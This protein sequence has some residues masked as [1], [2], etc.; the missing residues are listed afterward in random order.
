MRP[1]E[2]FQ[3]RAMHVVRLFFEEAFHRCLL[4]ADGD[5]MRQQMRIK[6][7]CAMMVT[8]KQ[9]EEAT[10]GDIVGDFALF[11]TMTK[12]NVMRI[13]TKVIEG[14]ASL[15]DMPSFPEVIQ[16]E[17]MKVEVL[18]LVG[19][20]VPENSIA[21]TTH[22]VKHIL[23]DAEVRPLRANEKVPGVAGDQVLVGMFE[24]LFSEHGSNP[25]VRRW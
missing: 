15:R 9:I 14:T 1:Y 11:S 18:S 25:E 17:D 22:E 7:T 13:A 6:A 16:M 4:D 19:V 10:M 23:E 8:F 21:M 20:V 2:P 3:K 24:E 5:L 12:D